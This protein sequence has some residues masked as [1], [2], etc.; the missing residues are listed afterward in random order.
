MTEQALKLDWCR[1]RDVPHLGELIERHWRAGHVMG[2]DPVLYAWQFRHP[3]R[4]AGLS[5]LLARRGDQLLGHLGL[6]P[7]DF[8]LH[9]QRLTGAWASL[10]FVASEIEGGGAGVALMR[11]AQEEAGSVLGCLRYNHIAGRLYGALGFHLWPATPRWVGMGQPEAL[12]GLLAD[13][14]QPYAPQLSQALADARAGAGLAPAGDLEVVDWTDGDAQAWDQTWLEDLAP[15]GLGAWLDAEFLAWRYVE[16]PVFKYHLRLARRPGRGRVLGLMVYRLQELAGRP[17]K[18]LRLVELLALDQARDALLADLA[19]QA[20]RPG[21][22]LV[23]FH[24]TSQELAPA[25][26]R[27]GLVREDGLPELLPSLFQPLDY[28]REA[29]PGALWASPQV[30]KASQLFSDPALYLTRGQSD[31]DRP[32]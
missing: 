30:G 8:N 24:C 25:L 19:A 18:V 6:I 10:W 17:Q 1:P 32:N 9:G 13:S 23:D 15:A 28:R 31:Q 27:A 2:R 22:A 11:K 21:V 4:P 20:A 26:T 3:G 16:H 7:G 12:A 5:V 29:L 14:P